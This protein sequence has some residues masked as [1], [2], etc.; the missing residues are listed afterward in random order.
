MKRNVIYIYTNCYRDDE[1]IAKITGYMKPYLLV[2]SLFWVLTSCTDRDAIDPA[3]GT[4]E[5]IPGLMRK[6][7]D[8]QLQH[9]S[10]RI[11]HEFKMW[12]RAVFYTGVMATY[13]TTQ[14]PKYREAAL[15]WSRAHNFETGPRKLHGDDHVIGQVYLEL[16]DEYQD[17]T[18]I[19]DLVNTFDNLMQ[20]SQ[21][22]RKVWNWCDGLFMVPP[23]FAHLAQVTR[24]DEYL[25]YMDTMWWDTHNLL[26]SKENHLFFRDIRYLDSARLHQRTLFWSRGNGWVLGGTVRVLQHMPAED[27]RRARYVQLLQE[28]AAA[29]VP[30]QRE[31]GLWSPNLLDPTEYPYPETSGTG[32]F[33]Y[34]IAWGINEGHLARDTYLPVATKAWNGLVRVVND[35]GKLG[36]VQQPWDRP[37]IVR[38]DGTYEY[39]VG[40]FLLAGSEVF[41]LLSH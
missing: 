8:W 18:M 33:T 40:A 3:Y 4:G 16:Y 11:D 2:C 1:K 27:P 32:F 31:D 26:Y 13:R 35:Q 12:E 38:A 20:Y 19:Q 25:Q 21:Q 23:A 15:Q 22:G 30:L 29:L 10:A 41:S 6:V 24:K 14:D 39:G 37:G 28:M 36:W 9:P 5:T 34:A 7:C 17:P